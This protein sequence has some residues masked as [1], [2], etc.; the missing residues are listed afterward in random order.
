MSF[1][2]R[3]RKIQSESGKFIPA[4]QTDSTIGSGRF[5]GIVAEALRRDFGATNAAVKIVVGFTHANERAVKNWFEAKNAPAGPHLISL[6]RHSDAMLETFLLL[7][8]RKDLLTV[9]KFSD[10]RQKLREM[11]RL[12][13]DLESNS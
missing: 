12:L 4:Q 10:V 9:K 8:G 2:K 11:L 13:A 5:A 3:D 1:T 6:V 7:A